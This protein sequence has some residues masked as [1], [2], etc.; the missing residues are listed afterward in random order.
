MKDTDVYDTRIRKAYELL[1]STLDEYSE[2]AINTTNDFVV[3]NYVVKSD[4]SWL[5]TFYSDTNLLADEVEIEFFETDVDDYYV[6][7]YKKVYTRLFTEQK[8]Q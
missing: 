2:G 3:N 6:N 7:L 1:A 4:I 5:V 8:E